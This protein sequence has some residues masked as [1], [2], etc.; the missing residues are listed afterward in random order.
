[1]SD[2]ID[3]ETIDGT[4]FGLCPIGSPPSK[5]PGWVYLRKNRNFTNRYL[6][7]AEE[8]KNCRMVEVGVDQGG[9]TSFFTKLFRPE[10][11]LALELSDQPVASVMD[12]LT[13]HDREK[14]VDIHWGIDQSDPIRVPELVQLT[15]A[16]QPLD[17]IV[18][19]AS[20]LLTPTTAT[21]EMLF[22][23]LRP[24]G[25]YVIED[26]SWRH[27]KER[28]INKALSSDSS[29]ELAK[30]ATAALDPTI[31]FEMPMS[32]LICQLVIAAGFSLDWIT[33][34]RATDGFCEIRRGDADIPP[35]TPIS[36]YLGYI[37]NRMLSMNND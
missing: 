21:F 26:W 27:L 8:F 31:E 15:F 29:G 35:G 20:H 32:F 5:T 4:V 19:D 18:D 7:L 37:G 24:G 6:S 23:K 36:D 17:L 13:K 11:L 22:P 10:N 34:V 30:R 28:G 3:T 14:S 9:S 1:M 2:S 16:E 12:F 33:S 25:L